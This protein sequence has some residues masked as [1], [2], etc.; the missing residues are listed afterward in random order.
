MTD[1]S[2]IDPHET[3]VTPVSTDAS[4]L[5]VRAFQFPDAIDLDAV[6][7]RYPPSRI[8]SLDPLVLKLTGSAH[9]VVLPFGTAVFWQCDDALRAKVIDEIRQ[10][11]ASEA[12]AFEAREVLTVQLGESED[13]VSRKGVFLRGLTVEHVK[14]VSE[15]FGQSVAL[16]QSELLVGRALR[17]TTPIVR[18]LETRGA[19]IPS[20]KN[21]LRTVGFT[22]AVRES[23]LAKLS[24]LDAP[25]ETRRSERLSRLHG[26]LLDRFALRQRVAG[27]QEK[28]GFLSDLN[29]LLMT[30]LQNRTSHRLEWIVILLIV[31]EVIF[32][33][34]HYFSGTG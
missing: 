9:V 19:L 24:L 15:A 16:E 4:R 25:A 3:L 32:S 10:A 26:Q 8:L 7:N 22:L 23:I 21:I 13:R 29:Q 33:F 27:L 11:S 30:L 1:R 12:P 18:A 20:E 31:I 6:Q 2:E 17:E 14:I 5:E 28:V 34:I